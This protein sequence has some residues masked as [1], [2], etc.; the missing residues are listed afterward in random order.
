MQS[1]TIWNLNLFCIIIFNLRIFNFQS[2]YNISIF[3]R[4]ERIWKI[5]LSVLSHGEL[6]PKR[7]ICKSNDFV[8]VWKFFIENWLKI[9]KLKIENYFDSFF[10]Y[11]AFVCD[12]LKPCF[13]YE[14]ILASV[15]LSLFW[16]KPT[17]FFGELMKLGMV[18]AVTKIALDFFCVL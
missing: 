5:Y 18:W 9:A 10:V 16:N 7:V 17:D 2:I 12:F 11:T 4:N 15:I 13:A 1:K 14:P 6:W 3:K 8:H